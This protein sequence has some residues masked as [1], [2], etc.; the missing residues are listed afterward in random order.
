MTS[1]QERKRERES[2]REERE[3]EIVVQQLRELNLTLSG[4]LTF[5]DVISLIW[6]WAFSSP[7]SER[8]KDTYYLFPANHQLCELCYS[9]GTIRKINPK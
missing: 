6:R 8:T 1:G 5:L 9:K 3:G 4:Y 2:E 7:E